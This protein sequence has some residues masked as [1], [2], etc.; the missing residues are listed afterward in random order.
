[1]CCTHKETI[2]KDKISNV[3]RGYENRNN[4]EGKIKLNNKQQIY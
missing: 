2:E 4:A 1:V 3:Y